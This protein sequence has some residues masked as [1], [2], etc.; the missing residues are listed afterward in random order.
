M[1]VL[2]GKRKRRTQEQSH[3]SDTMQEVEQEAT[4]ATDEDVQAAFQRAF[5]AK[6]KPLEAR[7]IVERNHEHMSEDEQQEIESD[8]EGIISE[9]DD[10]AIQVVEYSEFSGKTDADDV[11]R[12]EMRAFMVIRSTF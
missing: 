4:L 12:R 10:K 6:F 8:W 1:A 9:E 5:E 2:L 11:L 3:E 7:L